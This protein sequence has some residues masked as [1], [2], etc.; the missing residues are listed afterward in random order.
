MIRTE[1]EQRE[2]AQRRHDDERA[3]SLGAHDSDWF[4]DCGSGL[5]VWSRL[6]MGLERT[7][8]GKMVN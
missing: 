5:C 8:E 7:K 6:L 4:T 1:I 3:R 2:V